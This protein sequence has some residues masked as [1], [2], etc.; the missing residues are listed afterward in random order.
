MHMQDKKHCPGCDRDLELNNFAW[1]HMARG[2]RQTWCRACLKEAN[3]VHYL[4]NAQAYK[5]RA[6]ER[7][8]RMR[9]ENKQKLLVYLQEH[10]CVDCGCSD[11]RVLDFDHVRGKKIENIAVLISQ[12]TPWPRIEAEI[13]KCEVRCA[14]CH[15][16]KTTERGGWR[17]GLLGQSNEQG[18][19]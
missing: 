11:I 1:K 2:I 18:L 4:N 13:A 17:R 5:D 10:H 16:I 8:T 12:G 15:R 7:N 19:A 9:N 3:R 6:I 14:N